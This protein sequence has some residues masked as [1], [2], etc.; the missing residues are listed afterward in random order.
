MGSGRMKD[1]N[2]LQMR[3]HPSRGRRC[4]E[5]GGRSTKKRGVAYPG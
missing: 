4:S 1:E 5:A 3:R 2:R